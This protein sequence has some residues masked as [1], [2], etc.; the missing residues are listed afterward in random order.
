M[1]KLTLDRIGRS[2]SRHTVPATAATPSLNDAIMALSPIGY[3]KLNEPSGT[4]ATDSS[5]NGR[6][7]TYTGSGYTLQGATGG[8]GNLYADFGN[9]GNS[10][11]VSIADN[12]VWSIDNG[13]TGMSW[14]A[15]CKPDSVAGTTAQQVISK[16]ASSNYEWGLVYNEGTGGISKA[17]VFTSGGSGIIRAT[18]SGVFTTAWNATC[19]VV[20][21]VLSSDKFAIYRNSNTGIHTD[22]GSSASGY[23]NGTAAVYIGWRADSAAGQ[24]WQGGLAHVAIFDGVLNTTQIQTLMDAADAEGWF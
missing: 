2:R 1:G 4:T 16:G 3:W 9:G 20:G 11:H 13:A 12:N 24:Y 21:G 14:F 10:S 15:L 19:W 23:T 17:R 8:D 7:G 18:T 6:N 5:G 22:E